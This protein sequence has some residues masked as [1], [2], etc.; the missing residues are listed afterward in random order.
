MKKTAMIELRDKLL[1]EVENLKEASQ[2]NEHLKGYR[3]ALKN[4]ANDI[5]AQMAQIEY[6]IIVNAYAAGCG[7]EDG[8]QAID[9]EFLEWFVKNPSCE[10]IEI[11]DSKIVKQHTWDGSNDGEIIWE[12]QIIIPQE[13]PEISDEAKERAKNYMVLKGALEIKEE[14]LEEAAENYGWR[15]KTNIFSDQVKAN[16]LAESAKQDFIE[17]AKWQAERRYSEEEVQKI[18]KELFFTMANGEKNVIHKESDF[19]KWFEQ[20]KKK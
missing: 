14:T 11:K 1:V 5:D 3:E 12:K 17:G 6:K 7:I 19:E 9:D 10:R 8:V 13:K 18:C 4:V 16:E 15:I 2:N 20:H